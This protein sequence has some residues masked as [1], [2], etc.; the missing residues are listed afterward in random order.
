LLDRR[1]WG[2]YHN[3]AIVFMT[4]LVV[5]PTPRT[6][7]LVLIELPNYMHL[8][9]SIWHLISVNVSIGPK[10]ETDRGATLLQL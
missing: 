10:L 3:N 6:Q 4:V 7:L 5:I 2:G 1:K 8:P 9:A